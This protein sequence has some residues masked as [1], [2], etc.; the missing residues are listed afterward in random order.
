M[1]H[2]VQ[3]FQEKEFRCPCCGQGDVA[4]S[5]VLALELLRAAW[6]GPVIVNSA[7]RCLA[8]NREV[9]G[10]E[11]SRHLLGLAAD[12]RPRD[13]ALLG[14]FRALVSAMYGR[15]EGWECIAYPWGV[16]LAVPRGEEK[17]LWGGR[18]LSVLVRGA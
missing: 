18:K 10:A 2:K 15:V 14:P 16:H 8:H 17:A 9:G 6:G 13:P 7:F 3:F 5:L 1:R 11:H 4:A 12:I